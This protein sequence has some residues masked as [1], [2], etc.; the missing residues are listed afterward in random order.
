MDKRVPNAKGQTQQYVQS[1]VTTN[2]QKEGMVGW[3]RAGDAAKANRIPSKLKVGSEHSEWRCVAN[4]NRL[5]HR[6]KIR[7]F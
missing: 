7:Q 4:E 5:C 1:T 2:N 6:V 3:G